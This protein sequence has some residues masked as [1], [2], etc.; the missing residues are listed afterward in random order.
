[1]PSSTLKRIV[2][3]AAPLPFIDLQAQRRRLGNRIERAIARVV[4]HGSF[5][6]G[7]EVAELERA[8]A[9][10]SGA[11]H[12]VTCASGT[13]ALQLALMAEGIEP[14]DAVLLPSFTFAATAEAVVLRGAVP[15]FVDVAAN[16][17]NIDPASVAAAL[18]ALDTTGKPRPRAIIAVDLFGQP[19]N[20]EALEAIAGPRRLALVADAAQ[21]FGARRGRR[22]VGT[23]G[24]MT[25]VS[26]YPAKPLGCYGDGGALTT[27]DAERAELL[28]SLRLHGQGGDKYDH[29]RVGLNSRLD[30]IQAAILLEKLA[31][32]AEEIAA[33][34]IVAGRYEEGL[35]DCVVTPA[36]GLDTTSVWAQYTVLSDRRDHLA[37][38]LRAV[39]IPTA[40]HYPVPLHRQVAY[41]EYPAAPGGLPVS[42]RLARQAISLPMHA[43]LA[44]AAQDRIIAAVRSALR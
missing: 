23:M 4:E 5:V 10:F 29:R 42:E 14:G 40:I 25:A 8:L 16:D 24:A 32:F 17:F 33:R 3:A 28:R 1:M 35:A 13:D 27:R 30:T 18:A 34:Q 9:A 22:R 26:F 12:V 11:K 7:P 39:G 44:P 19:A 37:A 21:S 15:V 6:L 31:I 41:R 2:L 38:A 20:Y 36:V 43:Y